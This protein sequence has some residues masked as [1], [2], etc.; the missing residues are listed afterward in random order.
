A[1]SVVGTVQRLIRIAAWQDGR[2]NVSAA[3]IGFKGNAQREEAPGTIEVSDPYGDTQI[4]GV[5]E[6]SP[7]GDNF[8]ARQMQ[9]ATASPPE[10]GTRE[11]VILRS[12]K[13]A[14]K[15]KPEKA[16]TKSTAAEKKR[17]EPNKPQLKIEFEDK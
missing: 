6:T 8:S 11:T 9:E 4:I 17:S 15:S 10:Q 3:S 5:E 14:K 2:D 13:R 7:I 12:P 1:G 16:K